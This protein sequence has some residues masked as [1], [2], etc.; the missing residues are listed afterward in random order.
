MKKSFVL[1]AVLIIALQAIQAQTPYTERRDVTGFS[2]VAFAVSGEVIISLGNQYSVVLEG[3][4]DYIKEIETKISGREL[5]IKRD[6]W[7]DTGNKKVLVKIT[8]PELKG[9]SVSGSGKATV[10]DPLSGGDL[11]IGISGSGKVMLNEVALANVECDISGSGSLNI[12]GEGT[13]ENLEVNI[14]GSGDYVG[15]TTRVGTLEAAISGSG[16]CNCYVTGML[17][18]SISG[19]GNISYSGTPKIDAAISGSGKVRMK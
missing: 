10:N 1:T 18:A 15:E 13:V 14:S 11:D 12:T 16:S 2:E 5:V 8:M 17:K 3:D 19:S 7:F 9:V 4:R 6:K